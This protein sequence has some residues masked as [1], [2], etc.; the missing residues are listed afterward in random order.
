MRRPG[1][2]VDGNPDARALDS[3]MYHVDFV[4]RILTVAL[5]LRFPIALPSHPKRGA[6]DRE[7]RPGRK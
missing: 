4:Y 3:V 6:A 2:L 1:K 7:R 5:E